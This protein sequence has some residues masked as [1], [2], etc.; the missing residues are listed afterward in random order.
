LAASI[1]SL[2]PAGADAVTLDFLITDNMVLQ[3][4]NTT[5]IRGTASPGE[6]VT[7]KLGALT[8]T[9]TA[10]A[11]GAWTA[12]FHDLS[13]A[14]NLTLTVSGKDGPPLVVNNVD[15]GDV[16]FC[17]GQSNMFFRLADADEIAAIDRPHL[18]YFGVPFKNAAT[19][20]PTV[21]AKWEV[22]SPQSANRHSAV[23]YYFAKA[24]QDATGVPI[25]II[26]SAQGGTDVKAW[27]SRD[28]LDTIPEI[29]DFVATTL[30]NYINLDADAAR[31]P[32]DYLAWQQKYHHTDPGAPT[33]NPAW[34]APDLPTAD[35][36]PVV[37]TDR[38]W[39]RNAKLPADG[40]VVWFRKTVFIPA[41]RAAALRDLN[42][43]RLRNDITIY[44]NGSPI[45]TGGNLPPYFWH[46]NG[47]GVRLPRDPAQPGAIRPD[48]DNVFALRIVCHEGKN[49]ELPRGPSLIPGLAEVSSEWLVK[50]EAAFPPLTVAARDEMPKPPEVRFE[51][52]PTVLYNGMVNPFTPYPVKGVL[53]YQGESSA[54]APWAYRSFLAALVQSWRHAWR[55][56]ELPFYIVQLPGYGQPTVSPAG[57]ND[58]WAELRDSQQAAA[59]Q[60]PGAYLAVTIDIGEANDIHPRNKRDVGRRLALL[61]LEH[62][63]GL[64]QPGG[65][66]GPVYQSATVEAGRLRLRFA[67][68]TGGLVA[69]DGALRQFIIS[70]ADQQWRA[71]EAVIDGDTIL[72]SSPAVPAP[73]AVRYAWANNPEGCNLYNKSGLPAAPFRTDDWPL[74]T[75]DRWF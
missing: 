19:P 31:F 40:G 35:W 63:Y 74:H 13:A 45:G 62:S 34:A 2:P 28:A 70:G 11:D 71:A 53:W 67:N 57:L 9:A 14:E 42:F 37:T 52:T 26:H 65:S 5:P 29:K 17:A 8:T 68:P 3:R 56:D 24:V 30:N 46:S 32:G 6:L 1:L 7:L 21:S 12:R 44:L 69:K 49:Q 60:I 39:W 50:V 54:R 38:D 16:W 25:G 59:R 55:Q 22:A 75:Q 27:T 61:A 51:Q 36:T 43:G 72:V 20:V 18:R 33:P 58:S 23:G 48:A 4:G 41:D 47:I 15:V 10:A 66:A 73:V 64:P